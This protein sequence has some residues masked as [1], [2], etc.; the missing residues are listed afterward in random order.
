MDESRSD[1]FAATFLLKFVRW[2]GT[3]KV[4]WTHD[5]KNTLAMADGFGFNGKKQLEQT[6]W[7]V[8][9]SFGSKTVGKGSRDGADGLDESPLFHLSSF[10]SHLV[11]S[12]ISSSLSSSCLFS[13]LASS[14]FLSSLFSSLDL[15]FSSH[16]LS[17]LVSLSL[18]FSVSLCLCLRVVLCVV[19]LCGVCGVVFVVLCG[20][21]VVLLCV[22]TFF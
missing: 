9:V 7:K 14:L 1:T 15:F 6:K 3:L 10:S 22:V 17:C 4:S 8:T 21:C 20:E 16:V 11:F 5:P 2:H 12:S 13:C 18:S 19:V